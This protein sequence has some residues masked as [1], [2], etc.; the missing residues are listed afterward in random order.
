MSIQAAFIV[1][2]PPLIV[3]AVGRG[4]E[5]RIRSTTDAFLKISEAIAALKPETVV[6]ISPHSTTYMDYFHISPGT[7]ANG[8]FSGF[9]A[10]A[11][12]ISVSYDTDFVRLLTQMAETDDFPAGT[13]GE[14]SKSL[15]HGVTVPL[16]FLNQAYTDYKLVRLGIS[17]L[18]PYEHYKL[19][20]MIADAAGGL[21]RSV[22]V[23]A[24]GDLSHKLI[25]SGPYGYTP[26]GP[27]FDKFI[28]KTIKSADF[29]DFMRI[30]PHF[31]QKSAECG[32]RSFIV[33]AGAL[34]SKAVNAELLS[35]EGPFGVG[36]A[37]ASFFVAGEDST[38]AFGKSYTTAEKAG[39]EAERKCEGAY[40]LLA[41]RAAEHY[42]ET[43]KSIPLPDD[44]APELLKNRAGVFVSVKKKG[45]LRGCIGTISPVRATIAA[46]IIRN[47]IS[48]VSEDNRFPPVS[49]DELDLL[50]YSVDVLGKA[51]PA[52]QEDLD[53]LR[54][55][56]IVTSGYKR[57]LLLP[58]LEGVDTVEMQLRIAKQKAGIHAGE[59]FNI[60]RFEVVRH[61]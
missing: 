43:G 35:Y 58:A 28:C 30:D 40:V 8:D 32:L 3:P 1:P 5:S 18:D 21:N 52:R 9:G 48:A 17:G 33:M 39:L 36:Y 59:A 16:Y 7:G 13:A 23:I 6:I 45:A 51:E 37:V 15:D 49:K 25:K 44:L 20:K 2:H 31:Q 46:E 50:S 38:R 61:R 11:E 26:E 57:G 19:G 29:I 24:S 47:A 12:S 56:V 10:R 41:R 27:E 60:E 22:V 14:E 4:E 42:V 34:D 53:P 55:G 54:Y